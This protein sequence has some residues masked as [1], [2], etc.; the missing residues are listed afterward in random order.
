[1]NLALIFLTG[2]FG[3]MHCVGMCGAIVA[4]YSTQDG[5]HNSSTGGKWGAFLKHLSYNIGRVLSYTIV[6]AVLGAVGGGIAGLKLVGEWFSA[7]AGIVLIVSGIWMLRIFPWMGLRPRRGFTK[8]IP[9]GAEKKSL[10]LSLYTRSYG[11]LLASPTVE[12]KFYIGALTPL[13]PCGLLYSA[14]MMAAA[15]GDAVSGAVTMA[16]FGSGIVPSLVVVG[17]VSTFFRFRLRTW[18]DKLAAITIILMGTMMLLRGLGMPL[19]WMVTGAGG[20][21]YH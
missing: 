11:A 9:L 7:L 18:G 16:L 19:P 13:L 20:G 2:F 15:S 5:F 4:A 17:Y 14:F 12:S 1:V 3:S 21:Q 10:L 8:D 6:G